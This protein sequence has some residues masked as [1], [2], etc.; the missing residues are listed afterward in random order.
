MD[1][2]SL[3]LFKLLI[4]RNFLQQEDN[5]KGE[6]ASKKLARECGGRCRSRRKCQLVKLAVPAAFKRSLALAY[7]VM[8][9]E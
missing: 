7:A 1:A 3:P 8:P 6:G 9:L 2:S 5:E 4:L